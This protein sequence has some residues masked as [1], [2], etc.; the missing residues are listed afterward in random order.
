MSALSVV[1]VV[2][3][4]G[5]LNVGA[6]VLLWIHQRCYKKLIKWQNRLFF[7]QL[8]W[9]F[10]MHILRLTFTKPT[11]E[12]KKDAKAQRPNSIG[13]FLSFWVSDWSARRLCNVITGL[14]HRAHVMHF[15][16]AWEKKVSFAW[17]FTWLIRIC[18]C[19]CVCAQAQLFSATSRLSSVIHICNFRY[20]TVLSL[21]HSRSPYR[22]HFFAAHQNKVN[23]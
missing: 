23:L 22:L 1:V 11:G 19:V 5:K 14:F 6:S 18:V 10:H 13:F 2:V 20:N 8:T 9:S 15:M 3:A 4:V 16:I 17:L 7:T 21:S 12:A